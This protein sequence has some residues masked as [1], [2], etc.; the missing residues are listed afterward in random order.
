MKVF[1]GSALMLCLLGTFLSCNGKNMVAANAMAPTT[2]AVFEPD[3]RFASIDTLAEFMADEISAK[4]ID[5]FVNRYEQQAVAIKSYGCLNH[6]GEDENLLD[7]TV[8]GDLRALADRL[9]GGSTF[10]MVMCGRIYCAV[11]HYL[12]AKYYFEQ[13]SASPLY[14]AEMRD[15]LALEDELG[16]LYG[17]LSYLTI[18]GGSL[19]RIT[20][21]GSMW[22]LAEIREN[23]YSKLH[24]EGSFNTCTLKT[25]ACARENL[26]QELAA[27]RS[28]DGYE[29]GM[30]NGE[31]YKALRQQVCDRADRVAVLLDKWLAS[32]AQLCEAEDIPESH[33]TNLVARLGAQLI[34]IIKE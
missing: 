26:L 32:R 7:K 6:G 11:Y 13:Y 21:S 34:E 12:T 33:T 16:G 3:V 20:A 9:S 30:Y 14:Q 2:A 29:E 17:D 23:D 25:L 27:A 18:W 10:D 8:C 31:G 1:L 28:I 4:T 22:A 24:S 19:A 15:W 5:E